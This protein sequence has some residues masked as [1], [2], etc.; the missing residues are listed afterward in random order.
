LPV[1]RIHN[2]TGR[3]FQF[4]TRSQLFIGVHAFGSPK[5]NRA[6]ASVTAQDDSYTLVTRYQVLP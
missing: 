6:S 4:Q 1:K 3:R 5:S 2:C